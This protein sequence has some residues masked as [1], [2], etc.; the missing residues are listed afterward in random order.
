MG[1]L[2]TEIE[3]L[4]RRDRIL[5]EG[6]RPRFVLLYKTNGHVTNKGI[7]G[8]QR[9]IID[10]VDKLYNVCYNIEEAVNLSHI[11]LLK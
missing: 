10:G 8:E 11:G 7:L 9:E 2:P 1:C 3:D 6:E 5:T 4:N